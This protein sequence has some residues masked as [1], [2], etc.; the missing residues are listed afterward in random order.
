MPI[1]KANR[2]SPI[3]LGLL[4]AVALRF[5]RILKAMPRTLIA[6]KSVGHSGIFQCRFIIVDICG[7]L[8]L[9]LIA[10]TPI[11]GQGICPANSIGGV[12]ASAYPTL[13]R[14]P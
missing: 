1:E 14:P 12:P 5:T 13:T 9:V 11:T 10:K 6:M 8:P 3:V 2:R 4:F 7:R